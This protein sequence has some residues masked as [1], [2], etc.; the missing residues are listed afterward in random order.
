VDKINIPE[1]VAE[2]T[3]AHNRYDQALADNNV[4]I[5][6][7]MF[8]NSPHTL[9][10]GITEN[11]YGHDQISGFRQARAQDNF[12]RE[13]LKVTFTTY[14]RNFATTNIEFTRSSSDRI[15]RQSQTW[16]RTDDGWR[17]VAAHVS[18]MALA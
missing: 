9:R 8:W 1:I 13:V 10:Y 17:I 6:N 7:E 2:V 11:L 18:F 3:A 5:L 15:G 14:G 12:A 4:K 16:L